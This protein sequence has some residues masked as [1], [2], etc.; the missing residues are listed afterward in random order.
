MCS[1]S[2]I[3]KA[4]GFYLAMNRD[5][6]RKRFVALAPAIVELNGRHAVFPRE[7][8]GGTWI[9]ANDAGICLALINWHRIG[10]RPKNAALSRGLV[11]REL[12]DKSATDEIA[13]AI[14]DLPLRKLPPFRLIAISPAE[15]RV[16]EWRWNLKRL[17]M[18][19]HQWQRQHWFSSGFDERR[20]ERERAKICA[21][22]GVIRLGQSSLRSRVGGV[23][24]YGGQH[25]AGS[26][27]MWLRRLHRSHG[28]KRGPF[29]IC[30]HRSDAATVSYTEIAV[31]KQRVTMRYKSGPP[32]SNG[33]KVTRTI[34][35]TR[36]L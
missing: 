17:A 32:C 28:P 18:H 20:A 23:G 35:L 25:A 15:M 7:P 3:P 13:T 16:T 4:R 21:A 33:A 2:F 14:I 24:G 1:V 22:S 19:S 6:K 30:M 31:S 36:E 5:E 12:A 9:S 29:S 8:T 27:L 34:S 26:S 11:V 10:R